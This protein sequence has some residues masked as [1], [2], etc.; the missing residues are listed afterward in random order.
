VIN[1]RTGQVQGERPYSIWKISL[2]VIAGILIIGGGLTF[3]QQSGAFSQIEYSS[4]YYY[5]SY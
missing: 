1:G 4:D 3:L 5:P 2:A